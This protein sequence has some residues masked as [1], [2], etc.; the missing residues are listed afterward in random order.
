[1]TSTVYWD[2]LFVLFL[3]NSVF[4][5]LNLV[6]SMPHGNIIIVIKLH[7]TNPLDISNQAKCIIH[8]TSNK[9]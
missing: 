9:E 1:M 6:L 8:V 2:F 5:L 7:P 3:Y 4:F